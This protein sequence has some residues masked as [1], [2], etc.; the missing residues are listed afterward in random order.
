MNPQR[1]IVGGLALAALILAAVLFLAPRLG[2]P[3]VL[4][5]YVEGEPLY[6]ASPVAGT[7]KTLAVRRGDL[8]GAGQT[9]FTVDP[10]QLAAAQ[11]QAGEEV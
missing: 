4:S 2:H 1:L 11:A 5:G 7:L 8:A 10:R 6:L 9:L 3:R